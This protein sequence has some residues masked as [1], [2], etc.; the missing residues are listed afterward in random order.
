ML[1]SAK[2]IAD[3]ISPYGV[4]IITLQLSYPRFIHGELMT[5]RSFSRNAA[6]SR[7]VPVQ[8]TIEQVLTNPVIPSYWGKNQSG[9]QA[10][11]ELDSAD[12]QK[13][14]AE[15]LAAS[16]SAVKHAQLLMK[17]GVHKQITNRLL[18]PFQE[19]HT[20]VT[21]TE[22]DNFYTLRRHPDAQPEM[23][24]LADVMWEAMN[25]STPTTLNFGEWH[26]PYVTETHGSLEQKRQWSTARCARVSYKTHDNKNPDTAKDEILHDR[27][28]Q[29]KHFSPF[30][31]QASPA[32]PNKFYANFRGWNSYRFIMGS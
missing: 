23:K 4:R 22:W 27:L 14:I 8:K 31:H 17:I 6:S 2:V 15:W 5:H 7:A 20:I 1:S 21:A 16:K 28:L 24:E 12:K 18:E 32:E 9:M 3:S 19:M 10:C 13:A 29:S 26:L 30:E 11:E 25:N